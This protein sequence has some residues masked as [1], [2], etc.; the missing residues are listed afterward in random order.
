MQNFISISQLSKLDLEKLL[1][2][3]QS[4]IN[5]AN[6]SHLL[7]KDKFIANLFFEPSTRTRCS[8]EIAAKK[9]GANIINLNTEDSSAKKG[10][11]EIDTALY[12]Q[13]MGV[14][15]FII[16]HK[17]NDVIME[18]AQALGNDSVVVNAGG[19]MR[20]HP[21]QAVLDMLTIQQCKPHIDRLTVAIIGDMWHSRVAHSDIAALQLLDAKEIRLIAPKNLLPEK[22]S[23][24]NINIFTD[25]E[26]GLR[27]VDVIITLRLQNERLLKDEA[28]D[29]KQ[30]QQHYGLTMQRVNLAKPDV[31]I[32][33]PGPM[34]RGVEITDEVVNSKHAV[35]FQQSYNGVPTRMAILTAI[36][37]V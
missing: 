9:L 15:T 14:E 11:T 31:I 5:D 10:E 26:A 1:V 36:G 8:F 4:F 35:I 21:S 20:D 22:I 29:K 17:E 34:N 18:V 33:H 32:M 27:N 23:S 37:N 2:A 16:R 13:T 24:K 30:F 12:L 3:A 28:L 19:G 7:L 25:V 6:K